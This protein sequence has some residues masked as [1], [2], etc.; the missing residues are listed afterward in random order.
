MNNFRNSA[1]SVLALGA[2]VA[3]TLAACGGGDAADDTA[4]TASSAPSSDPATEPATAPAAIAADDQ[5]SNGVS[6]VIARVDLPA[7]GFIAVHIDDGGSPGP[8]IGVSDLLT[9]GTTNDVTVTLDEP[10]AADATVYPMAHIDTNG[11]GIYEFGTVSGVDGPGVTADGDVAVVPVNI[12]VA[13]SDPA[14]TEG[15]ADAESDAETDAETDAGAD[16]GNVITISDFSFDGVAEVPIGTT[17]VVTNTDP[18]PHTWSAEDGTFD[19]G[20]LSEGDTF[21]FT[22]TEAGEFAY[23]C[24]FHPSM[25][26]TIV[27]TG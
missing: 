12:G 17:V 11:N 19:S 9:E 21:E 16:A 5:E 27:V 14:D 23:F 15:S 24:N 20:A 25:T 26:G 8:V 13:A 10:L 18:S 2:G 6:I 4:N 3:L 1:R 22:F 7:A